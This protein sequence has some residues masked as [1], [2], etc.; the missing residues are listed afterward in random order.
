[1][2]LCNSDIYNLADVSSDESDGDEPLDD[3]SQNKTPTA[4]I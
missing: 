3:E 4:G 1:M 2:T